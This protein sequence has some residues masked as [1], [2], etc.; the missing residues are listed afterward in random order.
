[1]NTKVKKIIKVLLTSAATLGTYDFY[2]RQKYSW[3]NHSEKELYLDNLAINVDQNIEWVDQEDLFNQMNQRVLPYLN[4]YRH[5]GK[6]IMGNM[7]IHYT[8]MLKDTNLPTIVIVHG[9]NE[10]KEKYF[11]LSYYFLQAG[12]NVLCYDQRDHAR[13]RNNPQVQLINTLDFESY[14]DDLMF[15]MD[16]IKLRFGLQSPCFAFG[17]SM[18][19]AVVMNFLQKYPKHFAAV[20]L[21]SP[22]LTIETKPYSQSL[23]NLMSKAAK[24]FFLGDRAIPSSASQKVFPAEGE[25]SSFV[26]NPALTTSDIRRFYSIEVNNDLNSVVTTDATMNWLN[27]SMSQ[28]NKIGSQNRLEKVKQ[29]I[30]ILR[31]VEDTIVHPQGIFKAADCLAN[32]HLVGIKDAGHELYQEKDEILRP[33]VSLIIDYFKQF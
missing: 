22:M 2:Y 1:M 16:S 24:V 30:L 4:T 29:A 17:H 9:L 8:L 32:V 10:F 5:E 26:S 7:S 18:G 3:H 15:L 11:E 13:S 19:G 27:T 6:V 14:V 28:L 33:Y 23:T 21:S 31:S 25:E 12:Y 20:V